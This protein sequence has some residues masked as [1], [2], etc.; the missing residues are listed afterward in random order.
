[1]KHVQRGVTYDDSDVDSILSYAKRI[2]GKTLREELEILEEE[3]PKGY[4]T[5]SKG[6]MGDNVEEYYFDIRNNNKQ[7][8]DFPKVSM[9]LK[10]T[11]LVYTQKKEKRA[12][13]RLAITNINWMT[14]LD[15]SF[16]SSHLIEKI[17]KVLL[18]AYDYDKDVDNIFDLTF[19]LAA[20]WEVPEKDLAQLRDDWNTVLNKVRAGQAE[21][22]SSSDTVY[23][24][25]ATTG[26]GHGKLLPQPH[27][28]ELARPRRWALKNSYMTTVINELFHER[29][30]AAIQR[31]GGQGNLSL[32]QLVAKRFKPYMGMTRQ[33]LK[34]RLSIA[35][36]P[37][38]KQ[39]TASLTRKILGVGTSSKIEEF[40]KAGVITRTVRRTKTGRVV[41]SVSFPA[42]DYRK[43]V[44]TE[45][46]DSNFFSYMTSLFLFVVFDKDSESGDYKLTDLVW[47]SP[48]KE[49]VEE[50]RILFE[51]TKDLISRNIYDQFT[52]IA[53]RR[54]E[55]SHVH[56]RPHGTAG[57]TCETPIGTRERKK[58]FWLTNKYVR[59][60][61][62]DSQALN[63]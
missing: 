10:T 53:G 60:V 23:L 11:G 63:Q 62:D 35:C 29:G 27:S 30:Y 34:S 45:W 52:G 59:Q 42:M 20:I 5:N 16:E 14:I 50:A 33:E 15:E 46:K 61:I 4:S 54:G 51:E 31:S 12:K 25:A 43:I 56:V 26:A 39:F 3:K 40:E 6:A 2:E 47:W 19:K 55:G 8:P 1:M 28:S 36:D 57:E 24:E 48:T 18:M 7:E 22:I 21:K 58:C 32:K 41:E 38:A 49:D 17:R 9:E 37:G 44:K 13:E